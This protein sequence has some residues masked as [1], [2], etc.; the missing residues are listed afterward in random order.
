MKILQ[1]YAVKG[2]EMVLHFDVFIKRARVINRSNGDLD[3]WFEGEDNDKATIDAGIA[4]DIQP[5]GDTKAVHIL[6]SE[7]SEKKI[8]VEVTKW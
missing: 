8:E 6:P 3:A 4:R 2:Q 5:N 7:T 1:E